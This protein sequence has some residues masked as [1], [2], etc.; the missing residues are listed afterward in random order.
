MSI[1]NIDFRYITLSSFL[2]KQKYIHQ[3]VWKWSGG[4]NLICK[5]NESFLPIQN[6]VEQLFFL[7][8]PHLNVVAAM[9]YV[10]FM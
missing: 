5:L 8:A 3:F 10:D 7:S 9:L 6:C 2:T 4:G 1:R